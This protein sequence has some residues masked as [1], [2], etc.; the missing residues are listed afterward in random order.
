VADEKYL[1]VQTV[2]ILSDEGNVEEGDPNALSD[3]AISMQDYVGAE[4]PVC[5][6]SGDGHTAFAAYSTEAC[7]GVWD[8]SSGAFLARLFGHS[9]L[10]TGISANYP[11]KLWYPPAY[12][13]M[14]IPTSSASRNSDHTIQI[15]DYAPSFSFGQASAPL[16][17]HAVHE[18][19]EFRVHGTTLRLIS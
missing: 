5:K 1:R 6:L 16:S 2:R 3:D 18:S 17:S 12:L 11:E 13:E 4:L 19:G 10:I 9:H 7:V 8:V 15:R 14:C